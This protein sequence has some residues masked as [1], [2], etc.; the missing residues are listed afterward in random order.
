MELARRSYWG[1]VKSNK[2]FN[3]SINAGGLLENTV[4]IGVFDRISARDSLIKGE[5]TR[6]VRKHSLITKN[7]IRLSDNEKINLCT[8]FYSF[9]IVTIIII[10]NK[11]TTIVN[12]VTFF[13]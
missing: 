7:A 3:F 11:R 9:I 13:I 12:F 8:F 2:V 6:F 10:I 4:K 5:N 1:I